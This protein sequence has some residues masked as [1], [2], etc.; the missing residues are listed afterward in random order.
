MKGPCSGEVSNI[1]SKVAPSKVGIVTCTKSYASV[2]ATDKKVKG[3]TDFSHLIP[4]KMEPKE[5]DNTLGK[6]KNGV[7]SKR[8]MSSK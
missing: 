5:V 6:K 7:S 3:P 1:Q 2:V 8:K 4:V